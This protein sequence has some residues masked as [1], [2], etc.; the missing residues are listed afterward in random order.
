[1]WY[2]MYDDKKKKKY[3]HNS[4]TRERRVTLVSPCV[5]ASYVGGS[6]GILRFHL[7]V[8]TY[9]LSALFRGSHQQKKSTFMRSACRSDF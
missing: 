8:K 4:E 3:N 6:F 7:H 9:G 1:M 5:R 2:N